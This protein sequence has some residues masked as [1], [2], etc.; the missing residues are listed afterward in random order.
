MALE[1]GMVVGVEEAMHEAGVAS[2]QQGVVQIEQAVRSMTGATSDVLIVKTMEIVQA[3]AWHLKRI[4]QN[5]KIS[6]L[7]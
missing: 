1:V 6:N 3:I 7:L 2:H 5:L 4:S